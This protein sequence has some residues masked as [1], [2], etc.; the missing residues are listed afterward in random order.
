MRS[1]TFDVF[2]TF[3]RYR[4]QTGDHL[5]RVVRVG[6][7]CVHA[8]SRSGLGT[9]QL[10]PGLRRVLPLPH[11]PVRVQQEEV[12][13]LEEPA[14]LGILHSDGPVKRPKRRGRGLQR[15][16]DP[17]DENQRRQD[18]RCSRGRRHGR[19]VNRGREAVG[20]DEQEIQSREEEAV[21]VLLQ[22]EKGRNS[23][24]E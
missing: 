11:L 1:E 7:V 12:R 3:F 8:L 6:K 9:R 19:R 17:W 14:E 10:P 22:G 4:C 24:V 18:L 16:R 5:P 23:P 13:G 20:F 2:T 21:E 15:R